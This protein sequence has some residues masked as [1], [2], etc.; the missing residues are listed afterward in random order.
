VRLGYHADMHV[1]ILLADLPPKVQAYIDELEACNQQLS[2]RVRSLEE[3]LRLAQVKR[4]APRSEKRR[5]R[6]FNEAEQSAQA[7]PDASDVALAL[8]DTGLPPDGPRSPPKP[9]GRRALPADLPRKRIEYDLPDEQ[10]FCPCCQRAMHHL[11]EEISE[12]LHI[13]PLTLW[14]WQHVR[15]K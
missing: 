14:V 15:F 8:P 1:P 3:L 10:K 4:Y 11:G 2:E 12:Q 7:D 5:E 13:P 6:V 9:R